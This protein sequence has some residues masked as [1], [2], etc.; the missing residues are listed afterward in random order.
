MKRLLFSFVAMMIATVTFAQNLFVATLSH[1]DEITN[2]YGSSALQWALGAAEDGDLIN[3]S[4]GLFYSGDIT[5]AVTIHG[6]GISEGEHTVIV[7]RTIL[8]VPA[9]NDAN[10]TIEGVEIR[11]LT[12]DDVTTNARFIK[13]KIGGASVNGDTRYAQ[14]INCDIQRLRVEGN[15][16]AQF[17]GCYIENPCLWARG[18]FL[19]CILQP[20][21]S[22]H[23]CWADDIRYSTLIDCI[24]LNKENR[25][26]NYILPASVICR[27]CISVG[28]E[29]DPFTEV[30]GSNNVSGLDMSV[31][32]DSEA[33]NGL[34]EEANALYLG[35]DGT[36]V[37]MY[38]GKFP[39]NL[40]PSY[41]IITTFNVSPETDSDGKID[42]EIKIGN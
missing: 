8:Y 38:G 23:E 10:F 22:E 19:H 21:S 7:D 40:T 16:T 26:N 42:V 30:S 32:I 20:S 37:G 41:P 17:W 6:T 18:D 24:I 33:R 27:N 15:A 39:F 31:F 14:F 4:A 9:S 12:I 13:C 2:Y 28:S 25:T 34:T 29:L 5:K 36:P 1:G 35:T 3:L 11:D